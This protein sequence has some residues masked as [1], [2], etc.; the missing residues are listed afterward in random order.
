M[1]AAG[2]LGAVLLV[3]GC[4][5]QPAGFVGDGGGL[6]SDLGASSDIGELGDGAPQGPA[7]AGAIGDL[8]GQDGDAPPTQTGPGAC[9]ASGWCWVNPLPQGNELHAIWGS[10]AADIWAVGVGGTIMHFDGHSWSTSLGTASRRWRAVWGAGPTD[11][12]IAGEGGALAHFDGTTW[13]DAASPTTKNL[14]GLAGSAANDVY[15]VGAEGIYHFDG[16]SWAH[17]VASQF[18]FVAAQ[19]LGA[20]DCWAVGNST[21]EHWDGTKWTAVGIDDPGVIPTV[22]GI[23]GVAADDWWATSSDNFGTL[24]HYTGGDSFVAVST[25]VTAHFSAIAGSANNLWAVG[26]STA[27][28]DGTKWTESKLD[29]GLVLDAA[30]VDPTGRS[31]AVGYGGTIMTTTSSSWQLV[32]GGGRLYSGYGSLTGTGPNDIWALSDDGVIHWDGAKWTDTRIDGMNQYAY[33]LSGLLAITPDDVWMVGEPGQ[34]NSTDVWRFDGK[35]WNKTVLPN[36]LAGALWAAGPNDVWLVGPHGNIT[37]WDGAVWTNHDVDY[38]D[39]YSISGTASDD[40][41]TVGEWGMTYHYDGKAWTKLSG[42]RNTG[43][44]LGHV[45]AAG[46]G[47]VWADGQTL[48]RW[49]NG[50]WVTAPTGTSLFPYDLWG[51]APDDLWEVGG[52]DPSFAWGWLAHFDGASWKPVETSVG[53]VLYSIWG[54]TD[55]DLWMVGQG[56]AILR[57]RLP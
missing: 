31:Y 10:G 37:H 35:K 50:A 18:G 2:C 23:F 57:R 12:W 28:Y 47:D 53:G 46:K 16:R 33:E 32:A 40:I 54:A 45:F 20:R 52:G 49:T 24:Y 36:R 44:T 17:P 19:C 42:T 29:P 15:A 30:F 39:L 48:L 7:D 56:D 22:T 21:A 8:G 41:W 38:D 1:R 26:G 13:R 55:R 3:A 34:P 51:K 9:N 5:H 4:H 11:V 6:A 14:L 43:D 27:H 25:G